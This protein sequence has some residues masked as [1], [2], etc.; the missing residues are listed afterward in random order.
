[1]DN[2]QQAYQQLVSLIDLSEEHISNDLNEIFLSFV[3]RLKPLI[4]FEAI[5]LFQVIDS[6]EIQFA[7]CTHLGF[8]KYLQNQSFPDLLFNIYKWV[9]NWGNLICL[10]SDLVP[11]FND[12]LVPL[13]QFKDK[14]GILHIITSLEPLQLSQHQQAILKFF[15][16]QISRSM[17]YVK[18]L[19]QNESYVQNEKMHFMGLM[20]SGIMH[21]MNSPLTSMNGYLELLRYELEEQPSSADAQDYMQV[22]STESRRVLDMVKSMLKYVRQEELHLEPT[23]MHEAIHKT[24]ALLQFEFKK[25][26]IQIDCQLKAD[27]DFI[28]A[29]ATQIQ[30]ILFNILNNALQAFPENETSQRQIWLS[31]Q[32]QADELHIQ[33]RDNAGGI[34][35]SFLSQ[36]FDPF[37]TTK[38]SG[39]G[40]GL[41]LNLVRQIIQKHQGDI[42]VVN[43]SNP[44]GAKFLMRF[45]LVQ[46]P[47]VKGHI[48]EHKKHSIAPGHLGGHILVV[49][50]EPAVLEFLHMILDRAG[51]Q[52]KLNSLGQDGLQTLESHS[53]DLVISDFF[54]DDMLGSELYEKIQHAEYTT[55]SI[56]YL[57]GAV[58]DPSFQEFFQKNHLQC[59]YKPFYAQE[60][61]DTVQRIISNK[62][63]GNR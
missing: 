22:L 25:Q 18:S 3:R 5:A 51:Y 19:Q 33:I 43:H 56:L 10:P 32:V 45:P 14:L 55:P 39:Q 57:T 36:I 11:G 28:M 8:Q 21:E 34:P 4:P 60:L 54:L 27:S 1:M 61:L 15:G 31:S 40:T 7:P 41:G 44:P 17:L 12:L 48:Q 26:H 42:T 63:E 20:M 23:S 62:R 24:L 58:L 6:E 30:Q 50:N 2:L 9:L 52:V 59:L 37:F 47:E 46:Y 49:D 38:S 13:Y 16:N 53:F 35:L 29:D